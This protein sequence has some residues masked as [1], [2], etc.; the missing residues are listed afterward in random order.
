MFTAENFRR[1]F[2]S[3]NR[4]GSNVGK[5]FFP[6]LEPHTKAIRDKK[7]EIKALRSLIG[8]MTQQVFTAKLEA[9]RAEL[10][11][12]KSN[13]SQQISTEL[14]LVS[15]KARKPSFKLALTQ[16]LGPKGK[17][18]FCIDGSPETFFVIKQLQ[19]NIRKIYGLKQSNRHEL[20]S[21]LRNTVATSFPFEV[22]RTD[23]S[24][25]YESIDRHRLLERL[26]A[27]Q[28]LSSSSK[29][30]IRQIL[31][32][33]G[34]ITGTTCGIPRGVGISAYLAEF[35]MRPI[36]REIKAIPGLILYCRYVDDIATIFARPHEGNALG[37]YEST[38]ATIISNHGLS[39]NADK[40]TSFT[41][42]GT[43]QNEFEYLGYRFLLGHG[44][45]NLQLSQSKIQKFENRI[46]AAFDEYARQS[47]VNSR[48][49]YRELVSR[50]KFLTGNTRLVNSKSTAVTGTYY[51]NPMIT[52]TSSFNTLDT[53]LKKKIS[54]IKRPN[55]RKRLKEYKFGEGF[56][57]RQFHNFSAQEF[58]RIVRAWKHV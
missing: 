34:N 53:L 28:L 15:L 9:F 36:D 38:V 44:Q 47:S 20:A 3:E 22:V 23:V 50:I 1:I 55:L 46:N 8:T 21:Q 17:P 27:D 42:G 4:K 57:Q 31:C 2:D 18:V 43:Q 19:Y 14:E 51:N 10:K 13:R 52:D 54:A 29:K 25:F 40:T 33:Y 24:S 16:K 26:E 30:Y 41:L 7:A 49:A 37:S 11:V 58:Q 45:C 35:Y 56:L 12:L 6:S 48:R 5:R 32:S 39:H